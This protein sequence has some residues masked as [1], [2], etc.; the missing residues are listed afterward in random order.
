MDLYDGNFELKGIQKLE[1]HTDRVWSLAW[2]P[3]TGVA[4]VPP[5][6]ASCSGDKT[7]RIWEQDPSTWSWNCKEVLEETYTRTVRSCAWSPSGKLLA[8]AS[9]DAT[10]AIWENVGGDY[11]CISTLE[12]NR[13]LASASD[14][15]PI[16]IWELAK[17]H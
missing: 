6:F 9:F 1:G 7:V 10:T 14:D 5:V 11:E 2:K 12:E 13:L 16:K 17:L 15:G 8:T 4:G 3:A